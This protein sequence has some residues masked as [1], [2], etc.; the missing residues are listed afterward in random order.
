MSLKKRQHI[1]RIEIISKFINR[2]FKKHEKYKEMRST[3]SQ[4]TRL[5]ATMKMYKITDI[6]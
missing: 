2:N 1:R 6:R 4:P 3:A 5:F